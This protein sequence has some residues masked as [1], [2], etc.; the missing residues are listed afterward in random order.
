VGEKELLDWTAA[1]VAEREPYVRDSIQGRGQEL[2]AETAVSV[3]KTDTGI[4]DSSL[5]S[6]ERT[7]KQRQQLEAEKETVKY[8]SWQPRQVLASN[9]TTMVA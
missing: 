6:G 2:A 5:G 7:W 4:G 9:E 3:V 8:S 1:M